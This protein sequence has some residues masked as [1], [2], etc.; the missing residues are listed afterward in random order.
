MERDTAVDI[1]FFIMIIVFLDGSFM[2]GWAAG[3]EGHQ[4]ESIEA[5][6]AEW[7]IDPKTGEKSF[8]FITP[9]K[10]EKETK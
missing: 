2:V 8:H 10:I 7:R 6:V 4:K 9:T 1:V 3:T 5:G